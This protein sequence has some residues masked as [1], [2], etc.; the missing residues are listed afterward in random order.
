[1]QYLVIMDTEIFKQN[2]IYLYVVFRNILPTRR[3]TRSGFVF[4]S[5]S[6]II[7]LYTNSIL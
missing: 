4:F 2:C 7:R 6:I 5:G 1:M 3:S